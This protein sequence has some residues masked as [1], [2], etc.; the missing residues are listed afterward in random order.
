MLI[1]DKLEPEVLNCQIL[2]AFSCLEPARVVYE[3]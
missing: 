1:Y 2:E 3:I